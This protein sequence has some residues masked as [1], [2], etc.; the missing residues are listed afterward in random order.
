[1]WITH[2]QF[3]HFM[4]TEKEK[5][6]LTNEL[7]ELKASYR[8]I[9]DQDAVVFARNH[10]AVLHISKLNSMMAELTTLKNSNKSLSAELEKYK[11]AYADEVQKRLT[12]IEQI[13]T[14]N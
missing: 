6:Q 9:T 4:D 13:K 14:N 10:T 5:V 12:L 2:H 7:D 11:Q 3:Q 1:M 8:A